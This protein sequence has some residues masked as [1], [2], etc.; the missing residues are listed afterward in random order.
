MG[1]TL[2]RVAGTIRVLHVDDEPDFAELAATF[3]EREDERFEVETATSASDGLDQLKQ[4]T[5]DCIVSDHDMP[6]QT[7]IE[8][9]EA[10]RETYPELPFILYTGK[11]SEEVASD[12]ISAGVTDYLQKES[13]TGQYTVLANRILNAVDNYRA[14][15]ELAEREKRLTLFFEQSPLG[16]IEWDENFNFSR[17]NAAAEGILG[18]TEDEVVGRSWEV[19][20]PESDQDQVASNVSDLLEDSGGYRSVNENVRSDGTRVVCE[21]HNR[22]VTDDDGDV[23]AIFSQFQ[24]ITRETERK[25]ELRQNERRYEAVFNDPNILVGLIDTEGA[26]LDINETAMDYIDGTL[27]DVCGEP[28]WESPWFNHSESLRHEVRD[29]VDRAADGAYVEF[30][31]DLVRP[32]GEPYAVE[33]VVRPVTNEEGDVVSLLIS[34]SDITERR[35]HERE[36]ERTNA[37]LSALIETLPVGILAE[38]T[39]RSVLAVNE[40]LVE[41]FEISG[42]TDEIVGADCETL[43]KEISE[44]FTEPEDFVERLNELV[45]EQKSV[46]EEELSLQDGRTVTRTHEPIELPTGDGHLWMYRDVTSRTEREARLEALNRTSQRLMAASTREEVAEIGVEAAREILGLTANAIHLY[47]DEQSGLVPVAQTEATEELVGE[48]PTFTEG[49]S[50]AWRVYE[51]GE[52]LAVDDVH[53]DP[54]IHNPE[55]P[56]RSELY[57]PIGDHGILLNGSETSEAFDRQDLVLGEL[58]AS[59]VATALDQIEGTEQLRT[60]ERNLERQNQRLEE[61]ASVVSHDLRNPLNVAHGRLELVRKECDSEQFEAIDRALRRMDDLIDSLLMLAREGERVSETEPV[62]LSDLTES[63]WQNVETANATI[64]TDVDANIQADRSRLAQ[65]LENL[66]RNA[67]EHGGQ[68]VTISIGTLTDGFYVEDDGSGIPEDENP[69]VFEAGYSTDDDGTG[70]GL[71]IV[72]QVADAHGWDIQLTSSSDGGARFDITGVRFS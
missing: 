71:S 50:I 72:K 70:F 22:V 63:C 40:R 66:I 52:P 57:L 47:N 9:L 18:Y 49:D 11:G 61:F 64:R 23:V 42:S 14:Q 21:W 12:A 32:N 51:S 29:W 27:D 62:N 43:A 16:V 19:I 36:L 54:D 17:L 6:G 56:V 5:F 69:D 26:V 53:A 1:E 15:N 30:E 45:Q 8:F 7:G 55:T 48:P 38:D 39:D 67:V 13:G 4:S 20:V 59:N 2:S 10:V 34:E 24:D 33:G 3:L 68:N 60:R 65:L 25:A 44:M 35:E 58:L 41:L 28:L 37:L 31:A 46:S